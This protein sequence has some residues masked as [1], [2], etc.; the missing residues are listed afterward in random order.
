MMDMPR[1]HYVVLFGFLYESFHFKKEG[2]KG[3]GRE[4]RER[5]EREEE[6]DRAG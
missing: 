6:G 5:S 1:V 3:G 2:N 4:V